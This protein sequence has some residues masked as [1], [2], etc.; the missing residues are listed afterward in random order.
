MFICAFFLNIIFLCCS[1]IDTIVS[2]A[3]TASYKFAGISCD[4][5]DLI[6]VVWDNVAAY[7][8]DIR[9]ALKVNDNCLV[10]LWF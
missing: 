10:L 8:D 4:A 3:I 5:Y 6:Q 7:H 9:T 2:D 1:R